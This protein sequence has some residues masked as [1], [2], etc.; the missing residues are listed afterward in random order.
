MNEF[1]QQLFAK[2]PKGAVLVW[3]CWVEGPTVWTE[4]GQQGGALQRSS[5]VCEPKNVG[6]ANHLT[7]E[8][9]AHVEAQAMWVKQQKKKYGLDIDEVML[10][11]VHRP[12][13]AHTYDDKTRAKLQWPVAVQPKLDGAR[14][15]AYLKD[16]ELRLE[17]RGGDPFTVPHI[18]KAI[19]RSSSFMA[20]LGKGL[21]LDGELYSHG[22]GFQQIISWIKRPQEESI[23]LVYAMYDLATRQT[24]AFATRS[25]MLQQAWVDSSAAELQLVPTIGAASHEDVVQAHRAFL[26]D[27]YEGTIIRDMM[28]PYEF[29]KR[30][31]YLL[32]FK[33]FRDAEFQIIDVQGGR[34]KFA[35]QAIFRCKN[36]NGPDFDVVPKGTVK[37]RQEMLDRKNIGQQLTVRYFELSEDKVPRFPVGVGIRP[38]GI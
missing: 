2:G 37:E 38:S 10:G 26:E 22:H 34:G 9:Q 5:K 14:C 19:R 27:G 1:T 18:A 31:P 4:W 8:Q 23:L 21:E 35:D 32:K 28:A 20:L 7:A 24:L 30:S 29:A 13:L 16:G 12:M 6:R 17:S 25:A 36:P 15:I 11:F 33:D 3:R